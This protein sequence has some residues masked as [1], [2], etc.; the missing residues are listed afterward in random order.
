MA[1]FHLK[2]WARAWLPYDFWL[3]WP[4]RITSGVL[5]VLI[6]M[7]LW[8]STR[9]WK[10]DARADALVRPQTAPRLKMREEDL[11]KLL[12]AHLFGLA[13]SAVPLRAASPRNS[14][15]L[16]GLA[17]STDPKLS[18]ADIVINGQEHLIHVG[19]RLADGSLVEAIHA[20]SVVANTGNNE[21]LITYAL[22][23][24]PTNA[25]FATLSVTDQGSSLL[26]Q[27]PKVIMKSQ[28]ISIKSLTVLRQKALAIWQ[29]RFHHRIR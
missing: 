12:N 16:I 13:K 28:T 2:K 29:K 21:S 1:R 9:I 17:V 22:R 6:G 7:L 25:R 14:W 15:S 4:P 23:P 20:N 3:R 8:Q 26:V 18:I 19:D 27:A 10:Q 11:T 5:L 24:A